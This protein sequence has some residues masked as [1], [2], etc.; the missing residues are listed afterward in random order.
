MNLRET[1]LSSG[2]I[3]SNRIIDLECSLKKISKRINVNVKLEKCLCFNDYINFCNCIKTYLEP[4]K[5][6]IFIDVQYE[7][8][9][10]SLDE[11]ND[12]T[13]NILIS[14]EESYPKIKAF[15]NEKPIIEDNKIS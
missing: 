8:M 10:L 2:L 6:G 11:L 4:L 5:C 1:L 13:H 3:D 15:T 9:T 12:F 14:L 7:S